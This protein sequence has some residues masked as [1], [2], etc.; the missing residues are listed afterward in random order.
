MQFRDFYLNL[1]FGGNEKNM[2]VLEENK[3]LIILYKS[4]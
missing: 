1:G 2:I 4:L 3:T